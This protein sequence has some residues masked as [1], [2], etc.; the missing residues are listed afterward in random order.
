MNWVG[1]ARFA[2]ST[3]KTRFC[4]YMGYFARISFNLAE[5]FFS[6]IA[7]TGPYLVRPMTTLLRVIIFMVNYELYAGIWYLFVCCPLGD[8]VESP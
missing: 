7:F 1:Y 3:T 8:C 6:E 4:D 5:I 2:E